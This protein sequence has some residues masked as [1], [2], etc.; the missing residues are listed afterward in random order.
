MS[1]I[2]TAPSRFRWVFCQLEALRHCLAPRVRHILKELP[3]TLD[4]TYERILRDINKANRDHAHRLLQC[5]TVA[6]RPLRVAELAEIL[7]IDF[8]TTTHGGTSKLN[9]D[10]RWDDQEQAVL[11]TCS[12]LIA[13]VEENGDQ[14][15][16][17]SHF[18]VKEYL[19]SPRLA[20]ASTDVSRFYIL[21]EPGRVIFA[22]VC[23]GTLL[24]LDNRVD[25]DNVEAF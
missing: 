1:M 22:R 15:V 17:F 18:S 2:F 5:L 3:E 11:S 6:A 14:V 20:D 13:V 19:T 10:W 8:R 23:L 24:Q 21:L 25:T 16:Q 7:A 4:E 9:A 12:S